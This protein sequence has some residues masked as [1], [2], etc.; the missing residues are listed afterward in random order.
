MK[1]SNYLTLL[2]VVVFSLI[3]ALF[4]PKLIFVTN[5]NDQIESVPIIHSNFPKPSTL[6]FNKQSLDYTPYTTINTNNNPNPFSPA[7]N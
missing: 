2:I 7:T 3:F 6:Y 4:V 1:Q 5:Y